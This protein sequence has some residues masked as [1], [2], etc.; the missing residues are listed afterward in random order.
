MFALLIFIATLLSGSYPVFALTTLKENARFV[1][2][3]FI[4]NMLPVYNLDPN[5]VDCLE[6]ELGE[7]HSYIAV[8]IGSDSSVV[9]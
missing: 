2:L 6:L 1:F 4:F 8:F 7:K 3:F 5:P 9:Y